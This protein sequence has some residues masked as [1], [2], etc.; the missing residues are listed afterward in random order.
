MLGSSYNLVIPVSV[1][2]N[3]NLLDWPRVVV[4][5]LQLRNYERQMASFTETATAFKLCNY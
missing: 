4:F 2:R 3:H 1:Q 5:V